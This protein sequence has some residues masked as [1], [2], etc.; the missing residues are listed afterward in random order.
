[1]SLRVRAVW[2]RD[3]GNIE[4]NIIEFADTYLEAAQR[5]YGIRH[6]LVIR[7]PDIKN[8]TAAFAWGDGQYWW[9]EDLICTRGSLK[10]V[11]PKIEGW[12]GCAGI[13][14]P[15][16]KAIVLRHFKMPFPS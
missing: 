2:D 7:I 9:N 13:R 14:H 10:F 6:A 5:R 8:I 16:V 11:V 15:Q 12:K 4:T 3:V 1:M